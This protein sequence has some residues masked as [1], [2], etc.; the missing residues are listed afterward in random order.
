MPTANA[1]FS[2]TPFGKVGEKARLVCDY[3]YGLI[4][5]EPFEAVC[6]AT[7]EEYGNWTT[8]KSCRS[9]EIYKFLLE[10]FHLYTTM[11]RI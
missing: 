11:L 1:Q 10:D 5:E 6:T 8:D 9:M 2:G 3:G 4:G 7:S